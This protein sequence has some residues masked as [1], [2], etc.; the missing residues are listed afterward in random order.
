[1]ENIVSA[2]ILS[3]DFRN[4]GRDIERAADA[5]C[6]YI[7]FDVMD[8]IFVPNISFGFP[9]LK[10]VSNAAEGTLDVHLMITEPLRFVKD[11]AQNGADIITF[12]AE[13]GSDIGETV[14]AIHSCGKK[15]GIAIKPATPVS[16]V[17]PYLDAADMILIMTVEP[18]F[19]GQ[20]FLPDTLEKISELKKIISQKGLALPIE[21]DGGING[22][23]AKLAKKAGA[24]I[25][26]A[27]SYLFGA[28]DMKKAVGDIL[29]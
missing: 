24:E 5:G 29:A 17:L 1:M 9:L 16:A 28:A 19:G 6:K 25:F 8:G 15:A 21:V 11:F 12:H 2:S 26:V 22:D 23:T 20:G 14:K 27:G 18:G 10:A 7:H 4:L 3:A 13:A